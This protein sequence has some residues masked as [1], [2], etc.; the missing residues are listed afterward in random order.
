MSLTVVYIR[1]P[2]FSE[3]PVNLS[4]YAE[5]WI[6]RIRQDVSVV[7]SGMYVKEAFV[8]EEIHKLQDLD[9][10]VKNGNLW[11]FNSTEIWF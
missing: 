8:E 10:P 3:I 4:K 1:V 7:R 2:R 9:G 6:A 11:I 5:G